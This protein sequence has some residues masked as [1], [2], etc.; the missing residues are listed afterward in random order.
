MVI[1]QNL[2]GAP[3]GNRG[4]KVVAVATPGTTIHTAVTGTNLGSYDEIWIWAYNGHTADV[5]LTIEFGGAT[6]PDDNIKVSV[7]YKQGLFLIVPG[8]VLQ[9]ALIV[10]AFASVANV[11]ALQ[12]FINRMS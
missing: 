11:V 8:L 9:N 10:K 3:A 4:I 5:D 1:K 2:S 12:G 6:V 7:P